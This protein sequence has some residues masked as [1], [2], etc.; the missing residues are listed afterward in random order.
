MV[1]AP[2][3]QIFFSAA[4]RACAQSAVLRFESEAIIPRV[5]SC[6]ET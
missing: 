4:R 3:P 1:A 6:N 5:R 2:P